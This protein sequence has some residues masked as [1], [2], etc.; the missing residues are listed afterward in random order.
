MNNWWSKRGNGESTYKR[1]VDIVHW[2]FFVS[3]FRIDVC[4]LFLPSEREVVIL[5][6]MDSSEEPENLDLNSALQRVKKA[7]AEHSSFTVCTHEY[8]SV[9]KVAASSSYSNKQAENE[10]G[11]MTMMTTMTFVQLNHFSSMLKNNE[12]KSRWHQMFY[13]M[14]NTSSHEKC[15]RESCPLELITMLFWVNS[16]FQ[17]VYHEQLSAHSSL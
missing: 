7:T 15:W 4:L 17:V 2:K 9:L 10:I 6:F 16:H 3:P 14:C 5:Q 13:T 11:V 8:C 1:R 12:K